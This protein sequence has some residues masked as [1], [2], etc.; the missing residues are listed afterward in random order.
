MKTITFFDASQKM[1]CDKEG[2]SSVLNEVLIFKVLI[3]VQSV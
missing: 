3:F 2:Y 1:D